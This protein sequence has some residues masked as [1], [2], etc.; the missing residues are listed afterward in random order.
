MKIVLLVA[1][2]LILSACGRQAAAPETADGAR[3]FS[4]PTLEEPEIDVR[5]TRTCERTVGG[6]PFRYVVVSHSITPEVSV[7]CSRG[8]ASFAATFQSEHARYREAVCQIVLNIPTSE[9][10]VFSTPTSEGVPI[11]ANYSIN[12]FGGASVVFAESD[13][14]E[15]NE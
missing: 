10:W 2:F 12:G 8:A 1:G 5:T 9:Y 4:P 6:V 11:Q 15:E 14:E 13:C 7:E 3:S